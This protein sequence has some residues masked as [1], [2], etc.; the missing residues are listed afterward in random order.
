MYISESENSFSDHFRKKKLF[1]KMFL[2][3]KNFTHKKGE[4]GSKQNL[5]IQSASIA[6]SS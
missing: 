2:A 4:A 5:I 3:S 1:T 6:M